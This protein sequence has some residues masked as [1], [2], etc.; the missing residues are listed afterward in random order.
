VNRILYDK[1]E[2]MGIQATIKNIADN[3]WPLVKPY[4]IGGTPLT[5]HLG[6][7][8]VAIVSKHFPSNWLNNVNVKSVATIPTPNLNQL[9]GRMKY[10]SEDEFKTACNTTDRYLFDAIKN[11]SYGGGTF[12]GIAYDKTI[13]LKTGVQ[14]T[15]DLVVH[16]LVH[17]L[18]WAKYKPEDFLRRYIQG[19]VKAKLVYKDNPAEALAYKF[20]RKFRDALNGVLQK[21][22]GSKLTAYS[23]SLSNI[24]SKAGVKSGSVVTSLKNIKSLNIAKTAATADMYNL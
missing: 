4:S 22:V 12:I 2:K 16:E 19:Y 18:Q 23:L 11:F 15:L 1:E 6:K 17:T 13:Y 24:S 9:W 20:E 5:T 10:K 7:D 14:H 21:N 3:A 8:G